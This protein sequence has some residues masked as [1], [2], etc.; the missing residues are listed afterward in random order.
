MCCFSRPVESVT[1]TRIF[2]RLYHGG[3]QLIVYQM[4]YMAKEDL[5]MIL[6]LP[7]KKG[8][9]EDA[10]KFIDL[11]EYDQF[12]DDLRAGFPVPR[13]SSWSFGCAVVRSGS[14]RVPL[15]VV[16]VGDY[17]ASFVP[18]VG[19]FDRLDERFRLPKGTWEK[20]PAYKEFG[21]AVFKLR[22]KPK[23]SPPSPYDG[24]EQSV[25]PM[26]FSFPT[27]YPRVLF[28]PTVHIHDGEVHE[29]AGFDHTL[30]CQT[31]PGL[32]LSSLAWKE[33][34]KL[35][36]EF[37]KVEKTKSII[38]GDQHCYRLPMVGKFANKDVTVAVV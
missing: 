13:K 31:A 37:M 21:F 24:M 16:D 6:P 18:T 30:Y 28:F 12:F 19:D 27:A 14:A 10:V 23:T 5:A 15:A 8:G 26:A 22:Q 33:S 38:A 9:S 29:Q 35:A 4:N 32:G 34:Q 7:I 36:K 1:H 3:H 11:S 2:T 25:H 17:E 20:L